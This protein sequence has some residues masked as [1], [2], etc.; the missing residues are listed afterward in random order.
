M[1]KSTKIFLAVALTGAAI[2]G[3]TTLA[4]RKRQQDEMPELEDMPTNTASNAASSVLP[5]FVQPAKTSSSA[6]SVVSKAAANIFSP[7]APKKTITFKDKVIALQKRLGLSADGAIGPKTIAAAMPFM[8]IGSKTITEANI[9]LINDAI[10]KAN[11]KAKPS[12]QTVPAIAKNLAKLLYDHRSDK[13]KVLAK[14]GSITMQPDL[15]G[16]A[17]FLRAALNKI[18]EFGGTG[19]DLSFAY[20]ELYKRNLT[21]DMREG[22]SFYAGNNK[23]IEPLVKELSGVPV[24]N[25]NNLI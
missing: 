9:Q 5:V 10:S 16:K 17:I 1:K 25:F 8:P 21:T 15:E 6:S 3:V 13:K 24:L 23:A 12:S 20:Y 7:T 14:G 18:K 19:K 11:L 4:A 2:F 22:S